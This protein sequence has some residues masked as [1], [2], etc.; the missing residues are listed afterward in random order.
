MLNE[1]QVGLNHEILEIEASSRASIKIRD[2]FYTME[3]TERRSIKP[4]AN[5]DDERERLWNDVHGQ[6]DKQ[7]E[8]TVDAITK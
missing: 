5:I 7:I 8:I 1:N 3:Y 6:V 4:G 2:S